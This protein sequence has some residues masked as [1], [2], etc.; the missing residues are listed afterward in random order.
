MPV[1]LNTRGNSSLAIGI[2]GRCSRKFPIDELV[3]D[4][5]YPGLRVCAADADQY[6]KQRVRWGTGTMQLVRSEDNPLTASGLT[7]A[8]R[9]GYLSTIL[10]WFDGWRSCDFHRFCD[11]CCRTGRI[12]GLVGCFQTRRGPRTSRGGCHDLCHLRLFCGG[13]GSQRLE[14]NSRG[15]RR[16]RQAQM[17]HGRR[18]RRIAATERSGEGLQTQQMQYEHQHHQAPD[19]G[20]WPR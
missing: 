20:A 10:G 6:F 19:R 3:P 15:W 2:C 1:F 18:Q 5:N 13:H 9:L 4:P 11:R 17:C 12:H 16:R 8:Q 14:F 7:R